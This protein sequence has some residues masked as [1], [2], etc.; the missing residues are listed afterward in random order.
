MKRWQ[1]LIL[2]LSIVF[3]TVGE[4]AFAESVPLSVKVRIDSEQTLASGYEIGQTEGMDL[5][6]QWFLMNQSGWGKSSDIVS[7]TDSN[8][9]HGIKPQRIG[10]YHYR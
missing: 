1:Y 4:S 2:F 7:A 5:S 8:R 6:F 3:V 10:C 9:P